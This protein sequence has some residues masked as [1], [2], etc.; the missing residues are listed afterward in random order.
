MLHLIKLAVGVR[1]VA[2]LA[3]LQARRQETDPPLRH[4]TRS[5]P[6]RAAEVVDGGSLYWVIAG[7]LLARQL[8]LAIEEDRMAD[9]SACAAIHLDPVLVELSGRPTKPFQGWRYLAAEDAP[10]DRP[11]LPDGTEASLPPALLRELRALCLL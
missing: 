5:M 11:A 8:I 7:S 4:R 6:R 10:A 3:E 9:G 2:H 1:D